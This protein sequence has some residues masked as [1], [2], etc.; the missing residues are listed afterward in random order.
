[1]WWLLLY[2]APWRAKRDWRHIL[3][4]C[5]L[6][7]QG[8]SIP[9]CEELCQSCCSLLCSHC[10]KAL[11][12]LLHTRGKAMAAASERTVST[13]GAKAYMGGG[14][15]WREKKWGSSSWLQVYV[16]LR[17]GL[18]LGECS[19]ARQRI[20]TFLCTELI[21]KSNARLPRRVERY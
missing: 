10:E 13:E 17:Y 5:G 9:V 20:S 3:W 19:K 6:S 1:M 4:R 11:P 8:G 14:L 12:W 18:S 7:L 21:L 15:C 2:Q 16:L